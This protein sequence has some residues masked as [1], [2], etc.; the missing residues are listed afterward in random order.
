MMIRLLAAVDEENGLGISGKGIPWTSKKDMKWFK[1]LTSF[2][3]EKDKP[4]V[5]IMGRATWD[6]L[7]K[8]PLSGRVNIVLSTDP[9]A[10]VEGALL[11]M[12]FAEAIILSRSYSSSVY[13]VGGGKVYD[14]ALK[15]GYVD[16][17]YL[18]NIPGKHGCNVLFPMDVLNERYRESLSMHKGVFGEED[19]IRV[20][21]YLK[22]NSTGKYNPMVSQLFSAI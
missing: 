13:I 12:D 2:S 15:S 9:D 20:K 10:K 4:S 22:K 1:T 21:V 16:E 14:Q 17:V 3:E 8:K 5:V 11:A 19:S 7:P 6:S 18:T